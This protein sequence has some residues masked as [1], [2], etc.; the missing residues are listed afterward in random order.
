MSQLRIRRVQ[1][2]RK[3]ELCAVLVNLL[4]KNCST[5]A[6][7]NTIFA[8]MKE[9]VDVSAVLHYE[10]H[11]VSLT[12]GSEVEITV[13]E[14]EN[15]PALEG[16]NTLEEDPTPVWPGGPPPW[17]END[18]ASEIYENLKKSENG[19]PDIGCESP[20]LYDRPNLV[21]YIYGVADVFETSIATK[22]LAVRLLDGYMDKHSVLTCRLKLTAIAS[23]SIAG[24][25]CSLIVGIPAQFLN[26]GKM[27][28]LYAQ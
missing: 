17:W 6:I 10:D 14:S 21:N 12:I 27:D 18:Y 13:Q 22:F 7:C 11:N 3:G 25:Y 1:D 5:V 28:F 9:L 15:P 19:F 8:A 4:V 26:F 16:T 24:E 2:G 23:F 20:N